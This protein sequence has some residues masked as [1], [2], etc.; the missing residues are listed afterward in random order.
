MLWRNPSRFGEEGPRRPAWTWAALVPSTVDFEPLSPEPESLEAFP[1]GAAH[2]TATSLAQR[3]PEEC[4]RW[5]E[6]EGTG[7][8][9]AEQADGLVRAASDWRGAI[10]VVAQ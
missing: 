5:W 10:R 3:P 8:V 1:S 7:R 6:W 9:P 4:R 2:P